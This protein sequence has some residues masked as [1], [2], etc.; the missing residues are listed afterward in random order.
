MQVSVC[1]HA[2][3]NT[4]T[5]QKKKP[6]HS[7]MCGMYL[8]LNYQIPEVLEACILVCTYLHERSQYALPS[9]MTIR[10]GE[11]T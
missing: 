7:S 1:A 10:I 4:H 9:I 3:T 6:K 8:L 5:Y 11:Q 2:H